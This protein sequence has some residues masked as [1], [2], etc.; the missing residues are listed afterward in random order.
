MSTA[1][2]SKTAEQELSFREVLDKASKSAFRGGISGAAAM[3]AN[4]AC[5]MWMRTTVCWLVTCIT[6]LRPPM[7]RVD[8][9]DSALS[10][11]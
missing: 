1:S 8:L 3:G 5:L 11:S 6:T 7:M 2:S 10:S 9:F 4:V